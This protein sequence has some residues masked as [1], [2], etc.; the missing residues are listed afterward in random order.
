MKIVRY[1]FQWLLDRFYS[2]KPSSLRTVDLGNYSQIVWINENLGRK[3]HL[4]IF[5]KDETNLFKSHI[6][7]GDTILDVGANIGY[8]TSLFAHLV[9]AEGKVIAIEPIPENS[10]LID[11]NCL[12]N[13]YQGRVINVHSAVGDE[14]F[15]GSIKFNR[16]SETQCGFVDTGSDR[17]IGDRYKPLLNNIIEVPI[18]SLDSILQEKGINGIDVL[19]MDIEGFEYKALLGMKSLLENESSKPRLML[20]E[21]FDHHLN[22]YGDSVEMVISFLQNYNYSPF[23]LNK[24]KLVVLT[25]DLINKKSNIFFKINKL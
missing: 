16:T 9:G 8:F 13:R 17:T 6:K 10:K 4:G 15:S 19:K 18:R 20:I 3:I 11:L 23:Y 22:H 5:E 21:L 14:N 12:I 24:G 7:S 2:N 1:F 25:P